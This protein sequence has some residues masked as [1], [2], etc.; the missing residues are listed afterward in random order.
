[1][2]GVRKD[3]SAPVMINGNRPSALVLGTQHRGG[4]GCADPHS[5]CPSLKERSDARGG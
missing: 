2:P 5:T 3:N 1:M 4:G